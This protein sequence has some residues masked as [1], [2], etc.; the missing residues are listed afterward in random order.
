MGRNIN[1]RNDFHEVG[2]CL[3]LEVDELFL[4][5][6]AVTGSQS[7]ISIRLQTESSIRLIPVVLEI[8]LES[9]IVQM[10]LQRIHFVV[11]HDFYQVLQIRHRYELTTAVYHEAAKRIVGIISDYSLR[12]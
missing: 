1:L 10:N 8:L 6:R 7:R 11:S 9:V 3:F 2:C 12:E 5:I 4:G